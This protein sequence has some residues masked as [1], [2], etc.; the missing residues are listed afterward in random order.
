MG[1]IIFW[2][3]EGFFPALY[4][5]KVLDHRECLRMMLE[6]PYINLWAAQILDLDCQLDFISRELGE[7]HT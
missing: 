7:G 4:M 3:S 5:R 6:S 2:W 1:D